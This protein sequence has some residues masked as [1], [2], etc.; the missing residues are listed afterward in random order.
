[1]KYLRISHTLVVML[2][3][4]MVSGLF[5]DQV[6]G[7]EFQTTVTDVSE[8][9]AL[10]EDIKLARA[11]KQVGYHNPLLP[12][13]FGADSYALVYEDRVYVYSTNDAI[14]R[15]GAGNVI[16][17]DYGLIRSINCISSVDLVNWTDHGWIEI[18]PRF[19]GIA[20]WASNSWAPAATYK[21]IEG[22]DRFFLYFANNASGIGV[23]TSD[24]PVGPFVDPIGKPLVSR[25]TPNA[26]VMWLFDPAVVIDNDGKGYL[27]FGGGV[28]EGMAEMPNTARVVELGEDMVSLG[29]TPQAVEAPWFFEAAFVHKIGDTFYY[30]YCTNW[31]S[32]ANATGKILTD[33]AEIVYMTSTNPMGP[34]EYQGSILK[35]PGQFFGSYGNN[36]HSLVE[37]NGKWYIFYHTQVL[38]DAMGI[39]GGYRSTHVD[40][41]TITEDG[42][43]KPVIA[44]RNGVEQLKFLD[45]YQTNEAET[46]AWAGNIAVKSTTEE[47]VNF[48]EVNMVVTDMSTGSFIGLSGVDFGQAGPRQFTAKVSSVHSGNVIKITTGRP[49]NTALG[50]LEVPNTGNL[51]QFVEVTV[52]LDNEVTGVH[53]LFF[54]FAGEGFDFDAWCFHN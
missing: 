50:Y 28:P 32:R 52:D 26:N 51:N 8:P 38:Q 42:V 15:D 21:N 23:L 22:K 30:S 13:R 18:G 29:G 11:Y 49:E 45:P 17:N 19:S 14:L 1:M 6:H 39:S 35:N 27:Y 4:F 12:H 5:A 37:F 2:V 48:G 44:T 41:V 31:S 40:E 7:E 46:M 53:D 34:W 24:S 47:S 33:V 3:V 36:H 20:T 25:Q 10:F 9:A 43:I 16:E 54:V